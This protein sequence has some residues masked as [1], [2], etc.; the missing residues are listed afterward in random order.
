[1]NSGKSPARA[2]DLDR[3]TRVKQQEIAFLR[4]Q[5][6]CGPLPLWQ[7]CRPSFVRAL[8]EGRGCG[9]LPVI[10]EYKRASP[11]RGRI[12]DTVSAACAALAYA[13]NGAACLSILTEEVYF[14]G[15]LDFLDEAA[16]V[17]AAENLSV[18]LLRKD[19]ILDPVQVEATFA[20]PASAFLLIVRQLPDATALRELR[21]L[22]ARQGL[23][24]VVEIFCED[25]V[26]IARES[27]A[28]I[29][30]VNAR[31]LETLRVDREGCLKMPGLAGK[32]PG[33]IWIAAS[34]MGKYEHLVAAA[35]AGY[36]AAL[37]GTA[38]MQRGRPGPDLA[39]LLAGDENVR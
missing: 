1:M 2:A 36:D 28:R 12:C 30:Q 10:A 3:F 14:D 19:F 4:R 7:G 9:P 26:E 23:D 25:E 29:I 31:D 35:Q 34:G 18:P 20:T 11:S 37:L 33:E 27:G 39:S 15:S 38:L 21:E 17:L 16:R 6:A 32:R 24:A 13:K 5:K 22:G 8:I